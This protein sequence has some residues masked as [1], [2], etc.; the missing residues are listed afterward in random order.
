MKLIFATGVLAALAVAGSASA[1][2]NLINN[3]SFESGTLDWTYTG[4][5]DDVG[6]TGH[7]AVVIPYNSS[8]SYPGGAFGEPIPAD[9]AVGSGSPDAVGNNALYFVADH[10]QESLSQSVFLDVGLYTIGFDVYVPFNGHSN[11]GDATFDGT[12][13][14]VD[15]AHFSAHATTPGEWFSFHGVADITVA[16]NYDTAFTY[17][18][19]LAP[20]ADFV[21]DRA[22]IVAGNVVPEPTT[23]A[24]MIMGF[25]GAGAMLRRR[26]QVALA[27]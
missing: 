17:N 20:A 22:Y 2:V 12:I 19:G 13:A 11:S 26:R 14:G 3:G 7:P 1:A 25:G 6:P 23:W 4:T 18:S 16:G 21:V 15:L 8:A 9:N 10:S 27:A 5:G 24:L